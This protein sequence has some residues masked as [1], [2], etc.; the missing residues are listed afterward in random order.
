MDSSSSNIRCFETWLDFLLISVL[1]Q[2]KNMTDIYITNAQAVYEHEFVRQLNT[3]IKIKCYN[4]NHEGRKTPS[5]LIYA[6]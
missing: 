4:A 1:T 5:L 3:L 6:T 2:T